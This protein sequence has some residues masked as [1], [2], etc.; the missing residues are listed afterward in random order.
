[1]RSIIIVRRRPRRCLGKRR[2][3]WSW[4]LE[5]FGIQLCLSR[6]VSRSPFHSSVILH[7]RARLRREYRTLGDRV[8]RARRTSW[9]SACPA[10]TSGEVRSCIAAVYVLRSCR[11]HSLRVP[12]VLDDVRWPCVIG[13]IVFARLTTGSVPR[14][15]AA[16][17]WRSACSG[18]R[19][20]ASAGSNTGGS[21]SALECGRGNG[22]S[23]M[24]LGTRPPTSPRCNGRC[25]K[26]TAVTEQ[27]YFPPH[28]RDSFGLRLRENDV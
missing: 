26:T 21:R 19:M 4:R 18:H 5:P 27:R 3:H 17:S 16:A 15:A 12:R 28:T 9:G 7:S 20:A 23:S 24:P 11:A 6:I 13:A 10:P 2:R 14:W 25:P 8:L 22:R 1:M